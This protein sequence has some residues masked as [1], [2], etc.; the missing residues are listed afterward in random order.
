MRK[1]TLKFMFIVGVMSLTIFSAIAQSNDDNNTEINLGFIN[2]IKEKSEA[3][4]TASKT[5]YKVSVSQPKEIKNAETAAKEVAKKLTNSK[6]KKLNKYYSIAVNKIEEIIVAASNTKNGYDVIAVNGD[7]WITMHEGLK[8]AFGD[9]PVTFKK[10]SVTL[11]YKDYKDVVREAKTKAAKAH[12]DAGMEKINKGTNYTQ[13]TAGF[14]E[15]KKARYLACEQEKETIYSAKTIYMAEAEVHYAEGMALLNS[16]DSF[17]SKKS[18]AKYFINIDKSLFPYKDVND[19]MCSLFYQEGVTQSESESIDDLKKSKNAFRQI[20]NWTDKDYNGYQAK[21]ETVRNKGAEIIYASAVT[22]ADYNSFHNQEIAAKKFETIAEEWVPDYKDA[23]ERAEN[24]TF[25]SQVYIAVVDNEGMIIDPVKYGTTLAKEMGS[26]FSAPGLNTNEFKSIAGMLLV[27][28]EAFAKAQEKLQHGLVVIKMESMKGSVNYTKTDVQK[29]LK[30][31]EV[32]FKREG[33][34]APVKSSQEEYEQWQES[35]KLTAKVLGASNVAAATKDVQFD[36]KKGTVTTFTEEASYGSE[37][38]LE[39]WDCRG[40]SPRKVDE[41]IV[42]RGAS[43]MIRWQTYSGDEEAKPNLT[44]KR[45]TPLKTEEELKIEFLSGYSA[46]K[47]I[48]N[49]SYKIGHLI[50]EKIQCKY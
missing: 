26:A 16:G 7:G 36:V 29:K 44:Q 37:M 18:A 10:E 21:L 12:W 8:K 39:I 23:K 28:P 50:S 46:D 20:S 49:Q 48:R 27:S 35:K 24:C 32:W 6:V 13:K 4:E 43:D 9:G 31:V 33:N 3:N 25:N 15:L 17:N 41:I 5:E 22:I 14:I 42:A 40:A 19:K 2:K 34:N 1:I 38:K 11:Q 45:E 30:E 47:I